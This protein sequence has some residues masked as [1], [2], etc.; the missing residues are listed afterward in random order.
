MKQCNF[1][2][3]RDA[4]RGFCA[5]GVR[6]CTQRA[7][8][9][10]IWSIKGTWCV[11]FLW[12]HALN[13]VCC[14][15]TVILFFFSGCI[16]FCICFWSDADSVELF[17]A[18]GG[19]LVWFSSMYYGCSWWRKSFNYSTKQHCGR[20]LRFVIYR[21]CLSEFMFSSALR[22]TTEFTV[23]QEQRLWLISY[24]KYLP[25]EISG[26]KM[27]DIL[28]DFR[29]EY[30]HEIRKVY[31]KHNLA[32]HCF[33]GLYLSAESF[34]YMEIRISIQIPVLSPPQFKYQ[35]SPRL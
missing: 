31:V 28:M 19:P 33:T 16:C 10:Q 12:M 2:Q 13:F 23:L 3:Q 1:T 32:F 8:I 6:L 4:M 9:S 7:D 34:S 5:R 30:L 24:T 35:T 20:V 17:W 18:W 15:P 22:S 29:C 27:K 21:A 26:S 14:E 25:V 11:M